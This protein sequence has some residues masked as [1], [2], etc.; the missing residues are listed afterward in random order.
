MQPNSS[1]RSE[2]TLEVLVMVAIVRGVLFG[3]APNCIRES[4]IMLSRPEDINLKSAL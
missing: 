3:E 4:Q 1:I 2:Q